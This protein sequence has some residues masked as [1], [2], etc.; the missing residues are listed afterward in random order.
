MEIG[1][2]ELGANLLLLYENRNG[3]LH[4]ARAAK[5]ERWRPATAGDLLASGYPSPRGDMY[6]VADLEF[7]ENLPTWA[8]SIDLELLT[9]K[10]RNGS[11]IVVTWWDIVRAASIIEL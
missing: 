10:A 5:V 8:N 1:G 4:V 3:S 2:R 11:P 6:F 7:I 9:S